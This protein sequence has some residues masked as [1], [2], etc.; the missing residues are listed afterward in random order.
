MNDKDIYRTPAL[1]SGYTGD[2]EPGEALEGPAV[3]TEGATAAKNRGTRAPQA[4]SGVA[5]GSG[6]GAGGGGSAEDYDS[7]PVAGGGPSAIRPDREAPNSGAD[8]AKGGSR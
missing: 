2:E 3:R 8:G 6:A 4:G 5:T 1:S 7:D